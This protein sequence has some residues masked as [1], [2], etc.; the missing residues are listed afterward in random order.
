MVPLENQLDVWSHQG[1]TVT[2]IQTHTSIR[3]ALESDTSPVKGKI[4]AYLQG[5]YKNSTNIRGDSDVDLVVQIKS[6]PF[7][8]DISALSEAEKTLYK[9]YY[10]SSTYTYENFK[11]E[12][13]QALK[14]YFGEAAVSEGNKSVKI[15]GDANRLPA[16]VVIALPY[17]RYV[18]FEGYTNQNFIEGIQFWASRD[19]RWIINYPKQ[20]YKNG[21]D[22]NSEEQTNGWYKPTVRIFK[23]ARNRLI[24]NGLIAEKLAPSYFVECLLY[25]VPN[26]KFGTNWQTTFTNV[27]DW[28]SQHDFTNFSCQN[29][30]QKLF[31][32]TPE[33]WNVDDANKLIEGLSEL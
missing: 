13:I 30:Q 3:N 20:H 24:D 32:S 31:G 33:Q 21:C 12:V 28:L 2:S 27:L 19:K 16:D 11:Q 6:E 17:R 14:S 26:S 29:E 25:N 22:K 1:A 9:K 4:D 8:R 5:S 7:F 10:S 15:K 18:R 23:N